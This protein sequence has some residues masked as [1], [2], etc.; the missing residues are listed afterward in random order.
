MKPTPGILRNNLFEYGFLGKINYDVLGPAGYF[1]KYNP[2]YGNRLGTNE[3]GAKHSLSV[4][5]LV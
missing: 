4:I 1:R 3:V 2:P 5:I